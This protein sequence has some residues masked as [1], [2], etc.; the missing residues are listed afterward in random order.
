M[1]DKATIPGHMPAASPPTYRPCS[2]VRAISATKL[3]T[4]KLS[5]TMAQD[6]SSLK[7]EVRVEAE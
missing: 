3:S 7:D 2:E 5:K 1:D 4:N 6:L